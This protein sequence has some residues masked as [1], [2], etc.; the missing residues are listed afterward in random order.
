MFFDVGVHALQC[1]ALRL[2]LP[3]DSLRALKSRRRVRRV[4]IFG[5]LRFQSCDET[6]APFGRTCDEEATRDI[7]GSGGTLANCEA[8]VA[9]IPHLGP[10]PGTDMTS[11]QSPQL[12]VGCFLWA[13]KNGPALIRVTA[14]PTTCGAIGADIGCA[15]LSG[16][17]VCACR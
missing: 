15:P 11:C 2:V 14:P 12:G 4:A 16:G 10:Y 13:V 8:I 6:C 17:R 9:G 7:A 5:D 1:Y 3:D